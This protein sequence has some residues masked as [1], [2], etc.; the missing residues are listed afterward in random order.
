MP[1]D[2]RRLIEESI[3]P[4]EPQ[5]TILRVLKEFEGKPCGPGAVKTCK[6]IAGRLNAA[7]GRDDIHFSHMYGM[8]QIVWDGRN[9]GL[10]L[11]HGSNV[12]VDTAFVAESGRGHFDILRERNARKLAIL[13]DP[14]LIPIAQSYVDTIN[15]ARFNLKELCA[16]GAPL[17][18]VSSIVERAAGLIK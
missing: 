13:A 10:L 1:T 2:L 3:E 18:V 6:A 14:D 12:N 8:T 9:S 15:L 17:D 11:G 16:Y 7:A 5:D 4:T